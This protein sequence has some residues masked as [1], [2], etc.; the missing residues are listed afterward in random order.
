MKKGKFFQKI[1][2]KGIVFSKK[3]LPLVALLEHYNLIVLHYTSN[4]IL[5]EQKVEN[6]KKVLISL[7]FFSPKHGF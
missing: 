3:T 2:L 7:N 1:S 6:V 4:E 5:Y